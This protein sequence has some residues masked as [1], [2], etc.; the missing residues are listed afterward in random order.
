MDVCKLGMSVNELYGN[1]A[2]ALL[3]SLLSCNVY[4]FACVY[5]DMRCVMFVCVYMYDA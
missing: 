5:A 4:S 1:V 2:T 3:R